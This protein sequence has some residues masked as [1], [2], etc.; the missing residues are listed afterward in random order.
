[1]SNFANTTHDRPTVAML[2]ELFY[3]G[4]AGKPVDWSPHH[5]HECLEPLNP[6]RKTKPHPQV[7]MQG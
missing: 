6:G 4:E 3:A 5:Q 1:M 7:G 2:H